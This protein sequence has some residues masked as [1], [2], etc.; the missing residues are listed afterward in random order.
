MILGLRWETADSEY[1][2]LME[3]EPWRRIEQEATQAQNW[4][5]GGVL[6]GYYTDDASTAVVTEASTAPRDSERG[7]NWFR[8]GA[9]GLRDLLVLRWAE[10]RR[11]YYIGEWHYHPASHVAPSMNDL[12]QMRDIS[13][14]PKYHCRE[15]IMVIL[16]QDSG[17]E[18]PVRAFVFPRADAQREFK[19]A[20]A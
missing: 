14:D 10:N 7:R 18:R 13:L 5:T 17:G 20:S 3:P 4:E 15:P 12:A 6:I 8:R 11:T 2:L 16:G 19:K 9:A 1:A